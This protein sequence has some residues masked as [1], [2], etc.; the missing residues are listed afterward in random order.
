MAKAEEIAVRE[1][2]ATK[3]AVISGVGTRHYYRC[4]TA[5]LLSHHYGTALIDTQPSCI[6]PLRSCSDSM[7]RMYV[8]GAGRQYMGPIYACNGCCACAVVI[9]SWGTLIDALV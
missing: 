4:A 1:H 8:S 9:T 3:I 2:R 5:V 6:T 7:L